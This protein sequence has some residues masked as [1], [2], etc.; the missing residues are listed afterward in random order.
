MSASAADPHLQ[1]LGKVKQIVV[2]MLE[3]RSFDHML[4]YLSLEGGRPEIDGLKAG[5]TNKQGGKSYPIH[6]LARTAFAPQED[7]DH[8][9]KATQTQI[10]AGKMSG[11]AQSFA[12]KLA[13]RKFAGDPGL[14]MGY[15]NAADLPVYDHL[16]AQFCVCDRWHSSVPGATW[17]NRL[18]AVAGRADG[19]PDDKPNNQPPLY[20]L[21]SFV[22]HLDANQVDWRWYSFD[23]GTLR[24]VDRDY[25]VGHYEHFRYVDKTKL[26]GRPNSRNFR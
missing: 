25:W 4:G 5:Q 8:S 3:N 17:P 19:S 23:P 2:L 20:N 12:A 18:Y 22:R 10:A 6:H 11:F 15:Y 7:P 24:C 26:T 16:A 9:G 1:N 21:P 14:V 13:A